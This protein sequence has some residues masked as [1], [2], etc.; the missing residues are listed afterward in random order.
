MLPVDPGGA[1]T[2]EHLVP[3]VQSAHATVL[4]VRFMT[5][6]WNPAVFFKRSA[7][8]RILSGA[9]KFLCKVETSPI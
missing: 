5:M 1:L 7:A 9:T 8:S 6:K 2:K 4:A 3:N